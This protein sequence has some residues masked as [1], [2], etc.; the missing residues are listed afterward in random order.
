MTYGDSRLEWI[1]PSTDRRIGY[2]AEWMIVL[3][4]RALD[5]LMVSAYGERGFC[6]FLEGLSTSGVAPL[7]KI[8][9]EF[10]GWIAALQTEMNERPPAFRVRARAL[11]T[12]IVLALYRASLTSELADP[13][14]AIKFSELIDH[15]ELHY[16]EQLELEELARMMGTSPTH[17]SRIFRREVGVPL[18]E[19]INRTRI[20]N[21]CLLLRRTD[22]PVTRIAIDVGYNNVS[23]FN[24][25]FRRI[26]QCSPR[27][28]RRSATQ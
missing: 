26:M 9:A 23:Y 5:Q 12:D 17:L 6:R 15:I 3:G 13:R 4:Q 25:Y 28:Y 2:R 27:E 20:R 16:D 21:A 24:R 14:S 19:Y 22:F 18:F 8:D 1:Y 11:V 7:G 10:E